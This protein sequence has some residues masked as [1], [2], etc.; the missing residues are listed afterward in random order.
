[1]LLLHLMKPNLR[2]SF[3]FF[4][5]LNF[6]AANRFLFQQV[7]RNLPR[8]QPVER[9]RIPEEFLQPVVSGC[10]DFR[11]R[12]P[13]ARLRARA[14]AKDQSVGSGDL[15][16]LPP[17]WVDPRVQAVKPGLGSLP[18]LRQGGQRPLNNFISVCIF[19][20]FLRFLEFIENKSYIQRC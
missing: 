9:G 4:I 1:M 19:L 18:L 15:R 13:A 12:L 10:P 6:Q 11:R 5:M 20:L 2:Q 3:K 17:S 16:R 7:R 14:S 8:R